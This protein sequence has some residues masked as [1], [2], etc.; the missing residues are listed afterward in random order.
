MMQWQ[1]VHSGSS[2]SN[3]GK[4]SIK[5]HLSFM[6]LVVYQYWQLSCSPA[7]QDLLCMIKPNSYLSASCHHRC[8]TCGL[9]YNMCPGHFGHIELPVVVYNPLV[10]RSAAA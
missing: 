3:R 5:L 1:S 8:N 9:S 7:C 4:L 10:F 2:D 6:V